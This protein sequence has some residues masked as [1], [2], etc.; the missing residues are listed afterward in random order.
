MNGYMMPSSPPR[1]PSDGRRERATFVVDLDH[2]F[3]VLERNMY[4]AEEKWMPLLG[5]FDAAATLHCVK[6]LLEEA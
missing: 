2:A 6:Y 5:P 3:E 1:P 4:K